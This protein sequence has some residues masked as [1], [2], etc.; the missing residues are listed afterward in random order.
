[1]RWTIKR[2]LLSLGAVTLVGVSALAGMQYW[3]GSTSG[4]ALT[5]IADNNYPSVRLALEMEVAKT[6]QAD[7]L[8]SYVAS[9]DST[10][11]TEWK[12]DQAEFAKFLDAYAALDNT[13]TEVALIADLRNL[14]KQYNTAAQQVTTLVAQ[15]NRAR[16]SDLSDSVLG[17]IEDK[18]FD[19]LTKLEDL[20]ADYLDQQAADAK[21][22][23]REALWLALGLALL[24][25]A[26]TV[27]VTAVVVRSIL[28]ALARTSAV[29]AAV[30]ANDLTRHVEDVSDDEIGEMN[31][32]LNT[33]M[34]SVRRLV[35]AASESAQ[36]LAAAAEQ[37]T[38]SGLQIAG[39]AEETAAQAQAVV[40]AAEQVAMNVSTVAAGSEEMGQAIQQISESANE[41]ATVAAEAVQAAETTNSTLLQLGESS[42]EIGNVVKV[43]NSI[44]E[45]TNLLALNATIEAARAGES[46]K[47][48]AVV[49]GE[50]KD[51]A[52][53]T[54]KATEDIGARVKAIQSDSQTA[55]D[56]LEQI[57]T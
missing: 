41:A 38:A 54:A 19:A 8:A 56:A 42:I 31:A 17:P 34:S 39:S 6:G 35:S 53:E 23:A 7:D 14:E 11:A 26:V 20:N 21:A 28:S 10:H 51:L 15:G 1:M 50:V 44:A 24:I 57:R 27:A 29:L 46:G 43:I 13:D 47:G 9:G 5:S 48:F 18:M 30:A 3:T 36:A 22:D 16:A 25:A 49:A 32:S 37:L 2:K 33:A 45:Q 4:S 55:V 12:T 52:Q 40:K